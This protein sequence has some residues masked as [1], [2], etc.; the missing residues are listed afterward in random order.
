MLVQ[1]RFACRDVLESRAN[2]WAKRGPAVVEKYRTADEFR[3][4]EE[5][6]AR[7]GQCHVAGCCEHA[8]PGQPRAG[9]L[10]LTRAP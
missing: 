5:R 8:C 9:R 10:G 4:E 3:E 1:V 2:K 6:E 7:A